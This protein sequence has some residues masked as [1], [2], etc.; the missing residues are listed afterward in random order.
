MQHKNKK[1]L[2]LALCGILALSLSSCAGSLPGGSDSE[3]QGFYSSEGTF[4]SWVG[5]LEEGMTRAEVFARLGRTQNEFTRLSRSEIISVIF[6]GRD[7]GVPVSF[8]ETHNIKEFLESLEGY[9]LEY[10]SINRKHGFSSPIRI[11]TDER[12]Y[13]YLVSLIFRDGI[14]LEKPL[15]VGGKVN[16]NSSSTLFDFFNPGLVIDTVK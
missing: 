9:K 2:Q 16:A 11:Q 3:N 12:G 15:L 10:K 4:K 8:Q 5:E 13:K 14:L 1:Y 7:S 6:G